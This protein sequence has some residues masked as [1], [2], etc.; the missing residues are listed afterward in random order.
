MHFIESEVFAF[1]DLIWSLDFLNFGFWILDFC[2]SWIFNFKFRD[3]GVWMLTPFFFEKKWGSNLAM[4]GLVSGWGGAWFWSWRVTPL[5]TRQARGPNSTY[6][7]TS[8]PPVQRQLWGLQFY[9]L[10]IR[11]Q[12][13]GL[14]WEEQF[15][16]NHVFMGFFLQV[17]T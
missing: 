1:G 9:R 4:L 5:I 8:F 13:G 17:R 15:V 2:R 10:E 11:G 6:L 3:L 16:E 7:R 14:S 12:L